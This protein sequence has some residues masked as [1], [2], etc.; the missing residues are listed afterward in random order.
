MIFDPDEMAEMLAV[1][2]MF[3]EA[4]PA[5]EPEPPPVQ[6]HAGFV[7]HVTML[8]NACV[9]RCFVDWRDGTGGWC[10]IEWGPDDD[11]AARQRVWHRDP[12]VATYMTQAERATARRL[13]LTF[14]NARDDELR[15]MLEPA[16]DSRA[17]KRTEPEP[18]KHKCRSGMC[19]LENGPS[20]PG[21]PWWI[22]VNMDDDNSG[23]WTLPVAI[24][25]DSRNIIERTSTKPMRV[26][27]ELT[28][29]QL[30]QNSLDLRLIVVRDLAR[31]HELRLVLA[32]E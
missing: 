3:G 22:S 15:I 5:P 11:R 27:T 20:E 16:Q 18:T 24:A 2:A 14:C 19:Q 32:D 25:P 23:T 28:D 8:V 21:G 30:Y 7:Q 4:E 13:R 12:E 6:V 10:S 1:F 31:G 26:F 29:A 9:C 17:A